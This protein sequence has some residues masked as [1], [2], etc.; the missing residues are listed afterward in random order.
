VIPIPVGAVLVRGGDLA[1]ARVARGRVCWGAEGG[2]LGERGQEGGRGDVFWSG[3][4]DC[5]CVGAW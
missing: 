1:M 5:G 3:G 4:V 2:G